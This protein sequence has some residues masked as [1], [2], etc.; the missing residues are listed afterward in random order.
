MSKILNVGILGKPHMTKEDL[1]EKINK[2]HW[3]VIDDIV[4]ETDILDLSFEQKNQ[5]RQLVLESLKKVVA[6]DP[7][8]EGRFLARKV[9]NYL[10]SQYEKSG[11]RLGFDI[12]L[13][14]TRPELGALMIDG[15]VQDNILSYSDW[16]LKII[17]DHDGIS[18][19]EFLERIDSLWETSP[20]NNLQ[21]SQPGFL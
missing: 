14:G 16:F 10:Y 11:E 18:L 7:Q 15:I 21:S 5:F 19:D 17:A 4:V 1:K 9:R 2:G 20:L 13:K 12:Y 6:K 8:E 3:S